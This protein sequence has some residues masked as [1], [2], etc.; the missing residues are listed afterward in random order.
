MDRSM[1]ATI[2]TKLWDLANLIT[3]FSVAQSLGYM[4]AM[5]EAHLLPHIQSMRVPI[6][7][8]IV[9]FSGLYVTAIVWCHRAFTK[10]QDSKSQN[11]LTG[12]TARVRFGQMLIII[13][14]GSLALTVTVLAKPA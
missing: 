10:L 4:Y 14:F 6:G 9:V 11:D 12:V 7:I 3:G 13:V 2:A 5:N 8:V 1:R